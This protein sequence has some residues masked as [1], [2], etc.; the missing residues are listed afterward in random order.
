MPMSQDIS[1]VNSA[2]VDHL[3]LSSQ[4]QWIETRSGQTYV[5]VLWLGTRPDVG[6]FCLNG[7]R[8]M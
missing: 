3:A 4:M 7:G 5:K 1:P 2:L 6:R 8:V